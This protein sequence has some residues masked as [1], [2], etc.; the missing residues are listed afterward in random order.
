MTLDGVPLFGLTAPA[1]LGIA[2]LMLMTGRLI[3]RSVFRDKHEESE[4]WRMAYEA[5]REARLVSDN[6]TTKLLIAVETNR[7]V[8]LALFKALNSNYDESGD[9]PDV[10]SED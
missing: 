6:Q 5:E 3:P 8:L 10:A 1:I 4:R 2:V 9:P 7:D